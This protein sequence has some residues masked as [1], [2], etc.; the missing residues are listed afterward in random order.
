MKSLALLRVRQQA[1]QAED[2]A[3]CT[4][5][6][7]IAAKRKQITA[8]IAMAAQSA[9][10]AILLAGGSA[11]PRARACRRRRPPR[12]ARRA[13]SFDPS[14]ARACYSSPFAN[15]WPPKRNPVV[16]TIDCAPTSA[17][18]RRAWTTFVSA[19]T[20]SSTIV[21][22]MAIATQTETS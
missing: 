3:A 7:L 4:R 16:P 5:A 1:L 6:T 9:I 10:R 21:P 11:E 14:T 18:R 12:P 13:R 17:G 19:P 2:H 8:R 15:T 22:A 20:M